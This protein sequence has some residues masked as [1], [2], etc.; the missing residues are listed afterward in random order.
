MSTARTLALAVTAVA[1]ALVVAAVI[2]A[3]GSTLVAL[4]DARNGLADVFDAVAAWFRYGWAVIAHAVG[5]GPDPDCV[6]P[7]MARGV[8]SILR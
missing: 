5:A 3:P 6:V 4:L 2:I 1:A 7:T 8:C